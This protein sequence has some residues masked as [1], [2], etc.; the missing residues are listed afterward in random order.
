MEALQK[1]ITAMSK[2]HLESGSL[3][4]L[5]RDLVSNV[6]SLNPL[7]WTQ[8]F[9]F[10]GVLILIFFWLCYYLLFFLK[11]SYVPYTQ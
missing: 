3:D 5:A 4:A 6:R 2:A 7:D 1:D 10:I 11:L 8:Y 9:A